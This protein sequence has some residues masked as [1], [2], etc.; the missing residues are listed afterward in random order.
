VPG[1]TGVMEPPSFSGRLGVEMGPG[2]RAW[3][4]SAARRLVW[5]GTVRHKA[6]PGMAR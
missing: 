4:V 6:E 5:P 2:A 1:G 3:A